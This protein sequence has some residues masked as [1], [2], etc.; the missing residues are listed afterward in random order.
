[1]LFDVH[2]DILDLIN[3]IP[4]KLYTKKLK[5][6]YQTFFDQI[7]K[8]NQIWQ[9]SDRD[10]WSSIKSIFWQFTLLKK[11]LAEIGNRIIKHFLRKIASKWKIS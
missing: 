2:I 6:S 7:C 10:K 5:K 9:F 8:N 1:M 3:I 4:R 11:L